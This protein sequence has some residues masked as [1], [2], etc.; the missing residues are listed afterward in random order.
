MIQCYPDLLQPSGLPTIEWVS[1][2]A[3]DEYAEYRDEAFLDRLGIGHLTA[4]LKD[5]WPQRGPQWD[6]LGVTSSGPVLVEAKAHVR[7]FFSPP[8]QAGQRSRKQIDRAF[9]SVRADLGVGR[10]TDWSELYYQYANRIA[11]LWWLRE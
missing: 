2:L 8:S 7:E 6:A 1:P 4:S 9:A 10:A 11:F 3:E 5:F